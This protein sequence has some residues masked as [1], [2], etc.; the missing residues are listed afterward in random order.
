MATTLTGFTIDGVSYTPQIASL[1]QSAAIPAGG[2]ISATIGLQNVAVPKT[3]IFAF[4]GVD[5][6]NKT[7]SQQFSVPFQ[8][9]QVNLT[10]N[11]MSNAASG[12]QVFA[13]GMIVSVYGA[14]MGNFAQAAGA[15]PLP[16]IWRDSKQ[17]SM[18]SR[19]PCITSRPTR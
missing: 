4:T 14:A 19:R 6:S 3:V 18:V 8:G 5:A 10:V 1:F 16:F 11:G 9:P 12:Q 7:W 2:S 13:P 17:R 15:V